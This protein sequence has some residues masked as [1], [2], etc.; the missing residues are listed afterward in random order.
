V[1]LFYEEM[2]LLVDGPK[3]Y[4][5][6]L[7]DSNPRTS[8]RP[9]R[10]NRTLRGRK[11]LVGTTEELLQFL[12]ETPIARVE[13]DSWR[14]SGSLSRVWALRGAHEIFSIDHWANSLTDGSHVGRHHD[15]F[16]GFCFQDGGKFWRA[17]ALNSHGISG[18][19]IEES[20]IDELVSGLVER[21]PNI[22]LRLTR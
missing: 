20:R 4:R 21:Y 12:S 10:K 13:S 5:A 2:G 22:R 7:I 11:L 16:F 17:A 15:A 14:T 19:Y 8:S 9:L 1:K 6:S 18:I 3:Q